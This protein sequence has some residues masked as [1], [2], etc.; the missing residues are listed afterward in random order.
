MK[1][2]VLIASHLNTQ[3]RVS[4]LGRALE[5]VFTQKRL[6][7]RLCI[8]YSYE[9]GLDIKEFE[10]LSDI[11]HSH[12]IKPLILKQETRKL[13]FEHYNLL[14]ESLK[15]KL[16]DSDW[17]VFLDDDDLFHPYRIHKIFTNFLQPQL[18][19]VET[20]KCGFAIL[21]YPEKRVIVSKLDEYVRYAVK[22]QVF[23]GFLRFINSNDKDIFDFRKRGIVDVLFGIYINN[24]CLE[25][26]DVLYYQTKDLEI[27]H[28]YN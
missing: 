1:I 23:Q 12:G 21:Y 8:S 20:I 24:N 25:I 9:E 15:P 28:K 11:I 13:Q 2:S 5:S 22:W 26:P 3:K 4:T 18:K 17:F 19:I 16:T 6:P 14:F 10:F 27:I 7:D